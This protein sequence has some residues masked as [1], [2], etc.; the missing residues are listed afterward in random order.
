[1]PI[2]QAKERPTTKAIKQ[3]L[4]LICLELVLIIVLP[5]NQSVLD[6]HQFTATQYRIELFVLALPL[7]GA[8]FAAFY[9]YAKL[10]EYVNSIS[11]TVDGSSFS[12]LAQG[13]NWL[14][15]SLPI[16]AILTLI[17]SAVA[18]QWTNLYATSVIISNYTNLLF[19]FVGLSILATASRSLVLRHKTQFTIGMVRIFLAVFLLIGVSYSFLLLKHFDLNSITSTNNAYYLPTWFVIISIMI[20]YLFAWFSGLLAAFDIELYS[21]HS[22]GILYRK[23][24]RIMVA[25]LLTIIFSFVALQ[26]MSSLHP[27]VG[28]PSLDLRAAFTALFRVTSAVGFILLALG[29]TD[30]KKIEEV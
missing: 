11:S 27:T 21:R 14:V 12:K 17:L 9:G 5:A 7:F 15:W 19:S 16:T 8:W 30:L 23:A 24:F 26:Y 13:C 6:M 1:M 25:G 18:E 4:G 2:I 22:Q 20:P 28:P 29:A 3:V 10:Q